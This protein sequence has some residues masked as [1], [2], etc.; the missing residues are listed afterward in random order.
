MHFCNILF[1]YSNDYPPRLYSQALAFRQLGR[2][3]QR[4]AV[5]I[6]IVDVQW[7]CREVE[8]IVNGMAL[9]GGATAENDGELI[10]SLCLQ[11][12]LAIDG[13]VDES[14]QYVLRR[15]SAHLNEV[16]ATVAVLGYARP[17]PEEWMIGICKRRC[18]CG[19]QKLNPC[20][21][22]VVGGTDSV[23]LQR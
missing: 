15:N 3:E 4:R 14:S 22:S 5:V 23:W 19:T 9:F 16:T 11:N 6:G 7:L 8:D 12:A 2:V 21:D 10:L 17:L 1:L 18:R 13:S 20:A